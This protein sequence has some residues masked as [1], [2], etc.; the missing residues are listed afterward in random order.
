M[1]LCTVITVTTRY[2]TLFFSYAVI[3]AAAGRGVP[4]PYSSPG[5]VQSWALLLSQPSCLIWPWG[6]QVLWMWQCSCWN[7]VNQ[8][9]IQLPFTVFPLLASAAE[10]IGED[11]SALDNKYTC[12]SAGRY[13]SMGR[14]LIASYKL[15]DLNQLLCIGGIAFSS[16][17]ERLIKVKFKFISLL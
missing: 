15:S 6:W 16:L 17:K 12:W 13:H 5:D 4:S 7:I 11:P 9:T 8:R 1:L 2:S 10:K 3:C 14:H